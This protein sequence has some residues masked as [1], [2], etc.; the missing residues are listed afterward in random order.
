M[1]PADFFT[2]AA[3]HIVAG[4]GGVGKTTLSAALALAASSI[5]LRVLLV[6]IEGRGGLP[7]LFG[8]EPM[9][10]GETD[11]APGVRG[12]S[13]RADEALVEYLADHGFGSL[14]RRM[15]DTGLVEVVARGAPGMKDILLL[16]KIKQLERSG[17]ADLIVV[18]A[19]AS[20]HA[21]TFLRSP[22]GL[23]DAVEGGPINTQAHEVLDML[24]DPARCQV[25]LVTTPEETPVNELVETAFSLEDEIGLQLGPVLVNGVLPVR[26]LPADSHRAA[27]QAGAAPDD[28]LAAALGRAA[29]FRTHR[30]AAQQQQLDRLA[31]RLPLPRL[32]VAH[33]FSGG[34]GATDLAGLA[35]ELL[36]ALR[37]L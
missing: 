17:D 35:D 14:A 7:A 29:A 24:T 27:A 9:G 13:L 4:K 25:L 8:R 19:P 20:G 1:D 6:E 26:D 2:G 34:L 23:L 21:I 10:Y 16:G 11:L 28:A 3:V 31:R 36:E 30:Q 15:I 22:R 33:R 37:C 5:G 32:E 18:D 12:R